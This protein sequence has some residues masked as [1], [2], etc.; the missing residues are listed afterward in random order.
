MEIFIV[1]QI[2]LFNILLL[3]IGYLTS[4]FNT[5]KNGKAYCGFFAE[6]LAKRINNNLTPFFNLKKES[7]LEL[8]N[9]RKSRNLI[10]SIWWVNLILL[11]VIVI[12]T[13]RR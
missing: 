4:K 8:D 13:A 5:Q 2:C 12:L 9:I 3:V 7:T 11:I 10:V 1:V 6:V